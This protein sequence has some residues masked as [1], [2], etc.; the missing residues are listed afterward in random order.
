MSEQNVYKCNFG[1]LAP[2]ARAVAV[3]FEGGLTVTYDY[4]DVHANRVLAM[5]CPGAS[6][7]N[8]RRRRLGQPANPSR[9]VQHYEVVGSYRS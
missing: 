9:V 6:P 7:V 2:A 8:R 3:E 1:H 5:P 4:C